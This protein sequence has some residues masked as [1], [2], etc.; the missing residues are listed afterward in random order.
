MSDH[1]KGVVWQD[2]NGKLVSYCA[3]CKKHH[4]DADN[5]PA[6]TSLLAA[7]DL[8]EG[9]QWQGDTGQLHGEN[10]PGCPWCAA[11]QSDQVIGVWEVHKPECEAA[12]LLRKHGRKVCF[13][14]ES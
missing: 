13:Q 14:G 11:Q 7:L 4:A 12:L 6:I 3:C 1:D 5:D 2:E 9:V 8:I 10:D